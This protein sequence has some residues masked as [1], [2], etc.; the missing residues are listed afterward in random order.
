MSRKAN[1]Y[2]RK[3]KRNRQN[4]DAKVLN[5]IHAVRMISLLVLRNNGYGLKRLKQFNKEFNII[6]EDISSGLLNLNDI[7]EILGEETGLE[8]DDLLQK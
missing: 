4:K 2:R 5:S 8:G 6:L 3:I 7:L 1:E